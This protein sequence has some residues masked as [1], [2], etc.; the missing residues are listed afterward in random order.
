MKKLIARVVLLILLFSL[1]G[2]AVAACDYQATC[3]MDGETATATGRTK[4]LE[5]GEWM[6]YKH[7][8]RC[9]WG[10]RSSCLLGEV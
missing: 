7:H 10:R 5:S 2:M 6:E 9:L 1:V 4:R 3:P 8:S